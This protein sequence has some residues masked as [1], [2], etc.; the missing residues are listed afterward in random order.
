[1]VPSRPTPSATSTE[2]PSG[3]G[4]RPFHREGPS[5]G[6]VPRGQNFRV[7]PLV[8]A[9]LEVRPGRRPEHR[10]QGAVVPALRWIERWPPKARKAPPTRSASIRIRLLALLEPTHPVPGSGRVGARPVPSCS[11]PGLLVL[12]ASGNVFVRNLAEGQ[13]ILIKSTA[14]AARWW[15]APPLPSASGEA[16]PPRCYSLTWARCAVPSWRIHRSV[17]LACAQ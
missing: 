11:R 7:W 15:P 12:H 17:R 14:R 4:I 3:Q 6:R 1:M 8:S 13:F 16:H 5:S 9:P 2:F 10:H